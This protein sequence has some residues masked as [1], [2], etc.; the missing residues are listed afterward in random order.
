M[1]IKEGEQYE[2]LE[3]E[4][5]YWYQNNPTLAC[6]VN[7]AQFNLLETV[8]KV[9]YYMKLRVVLELQVISQ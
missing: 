6:G 7:Y 4:S 3:N 5:D 9:T 8:K 1:M 2:M